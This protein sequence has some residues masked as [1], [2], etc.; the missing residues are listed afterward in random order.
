MDLIAWAALIGC[1]TGMVGMVLGI[2][3]AVDMLWKNRVRLRVVPELTW[4]NSK[5]LGFTSAR[6][7]GTGSELT[8]GRFPDRL[9]IEV[10]NLSAFA[11]TISD[12]GLGDPNGPERLTFIVPETSPGFGWPAS[13]EPHRALTIYQRLDGA[14]ATIKQL[15]RIVYV[16]TECGVVKFGR[17]PALDWLAERWHEVAR[18]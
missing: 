13:V 1:V 7:P 5:G 4:S 10:V 14:S 2:I 17:S 8:R 9:A 12:A 15:P 6:R 16:S 18:P 3:T 11:V